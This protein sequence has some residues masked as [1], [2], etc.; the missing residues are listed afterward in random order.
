M[1]VRTRKEAHSCASVGIVCCLLRKLQLLAG[2]CDNRC[3]LHSWL[4]STRG[5]E[6]LDTIVV[7]TLVAF[8][9][10]SDV[11]SCGYFV[12]DFS[13]LLVSISWSGWG[14]EKGGTASIPPTLLNSLTVP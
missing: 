2:T 1:A 4:G 6:V 12:N 13:L 10:G 9:N 14:K 8:S 3:W 7:I 11:G 5:C